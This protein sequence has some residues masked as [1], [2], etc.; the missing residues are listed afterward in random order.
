MIKLIQ[1]MK[2]SLPTFK[3]T[4]SNSGFT[5]IEL[6]VTIG[7]LGIL[8]ASLVATIDPFEQ[9]RKADDANTKNTTVEFINA[10]LRYF[11]THS[12]L[13]WGVDTSAG[14][15]G[16]L[17]VTTPKSLTDS[18]VT[19]CLGDLLT[20]GEIKGAFTSATS[21]LKNITIVGDAT[22]VTAC[23]LPVSKSQKR[24]GNTKYT[25]AGIQTTGCLSETGGTSSSCYWCSL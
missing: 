22:S 7:I 4:K 16:G 14:C 2:F 8:A 18:S 23:F 3:N 11:T 20:D 24:D 13:M 21:V 5:L 12:A 15:N 6:L 19:G 10:S 9:L 25:V 1:N 17:P